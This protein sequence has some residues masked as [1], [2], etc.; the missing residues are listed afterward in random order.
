M[1]VCEIDYGKRTTVFVASTMP[2]AFVSNMAKKNTIIDL[3]LM[4]ENLYPAYSAIADNYLNVHIQVAPKF[5]AKHAI[6]LASWLIKSRLLKREIIFFHECCC[7]ILDIL[8][9]IIRPNG[10][11]FPIVEMSNTAKLAV[12]DLFPKGKIKYFLQVTFLWR[13]FDVYEAPPLGNSLTFK[14]DYFL[15]L[16]RYPHSIKVHDIQESRLRSQINRS[17]PILTGKKKIIFLCGASLFDTSKVL[18]ILRVIAEHAIE[19]G[20]DCHI[21]DHP[22]IEFRLGFNYPGATVLEPQIAVEGIDDVYSL[23]IGVTSNSLSLFGS[24]S[25]SIVNLID[26]L[27]ESDRFIA[28][29]FIKTLPSAENFCFPDSME[30][31]L[32]LLNTVSVIGCNDNFNPLI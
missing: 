16:K 32:T 17:P 13:W 1:E 9:K 20:F 7:P 12:F 6:Y 11:Y 18:F 2:F 8:I 26:G 30:Q 21:K 4:G 10:H 14:N 25:I 23:A 28:V 15:T 27:S 22:N 24:R 31:M 3:V 29:T 19:N 5:I